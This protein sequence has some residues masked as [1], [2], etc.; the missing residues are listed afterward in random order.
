M[1]SLELPYMQ[2][3]L[4]INYHFAACVTLTS[5]QTCVQPVLNDI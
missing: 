5:I 3:L 2:R 4:Q 1:A